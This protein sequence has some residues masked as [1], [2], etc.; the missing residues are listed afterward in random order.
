MKKTTSMVMV[1]FFCITADMNE[2]GR[3]YNK[4]IKSKTKSYRYPY[5][6]SASYMHSASITEDYLILS[7]IPLHFSLMKTIFT[8]LSGGLITDMFRWNASLPTYF[9]IISLDN[10]EEIAR[11]P[12][13]AFFTFPHINA[14]QI[15]KDD[16]DHIVIDISAYDDHRLVKELYLNNL[17]QNTFPSGL[18]YVRRF[19]LNLKTQ[20]C[21]EPNE[22]LQQSSDNQSQAYPISYRNSLVPVQIDLPRINSNFIGKFY[23][24]VY[25]VRGPPDYKFDALVKIDLQ[26]QRIAALWKEP[27]ASPSEPI[28]VPK[29]QSTEEDDG[30][31]LTIVFE[32][33]TNKSFILVLDAV[34]L[35]EITRAFLPIHIPFSLHGNFYP[36]I[37]N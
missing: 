14:Y 31:L 32:Q 34:T 23:R 27:S 28:F 15:K 10:G 26:T 29:P 22:N 12:R 4:Q 20:Q 7:E 16:E 25:A 2:R 21:T 37:S 18:G 35:Q 24:Y 3:K 30:I 8:V 6:Q 13:P 9:R 11:I 1:D 5:D 19:D 36:T 33:E 17:R